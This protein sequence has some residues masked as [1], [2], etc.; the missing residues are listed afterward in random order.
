M[1]LLFN[2]ENQSLPSCIAVS[3]GTTCLAGDV[4]SFRQA[5]MAI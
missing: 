4:G 5:V 2:I 3:A 1:G